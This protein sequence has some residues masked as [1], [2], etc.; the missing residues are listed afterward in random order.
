M[1]TFHDAPSSRTQIMPKYSAT[2][3]DHFT[4][5]RHCGRMAD[6]DR[7]GIEGTLGKAPYFVLHLK[8]SDDCIADA[9]FQTFGCGP[10]IAAG[11]V[12]TELIIGKSVAKAL[13]LT[14]DQVIDGLGG[15]PGDKR[16]CA[17]LPVSALHHALKDDLS[18]NHSELESP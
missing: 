3:M 15:L 14:V 4:S 9:Q 18:V 17:K 7:I 11:S 1:S 2:L 13:A 6:P 12:M 16:W 8:L 5:P 10:A